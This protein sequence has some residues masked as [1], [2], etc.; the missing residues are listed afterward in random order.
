MSPNVTDLS[1]E[2]HQ[3]IDLLIS[4]KTT[5]DIADKLGVHRRTIWRWRQLPIF[6]Q[7]QC[8]EGCESGCVIVK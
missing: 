5:G 3:A 2:Q 6:Q 8:A 1:D 4:G 7:H